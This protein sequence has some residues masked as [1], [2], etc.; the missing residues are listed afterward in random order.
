MCDKCQG[1][2]RKIE[3]YRRLIER[4]P[5]QLLGEGLGKLIE[6]MEAQ[7]VTLHPEQQK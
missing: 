1:L 5:D 2:D 6:D 3:Q 4:V 7:K